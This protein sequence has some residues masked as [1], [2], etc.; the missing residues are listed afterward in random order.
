MASDLVHMEGIAKS[1]GP[2]TALDGV[3]FSVRENEIVGLLG[4]NGAGKSTLIKILSGTVT[5]TR[6]TIYMRGK[7]VQI[8]NTTDAIRLGI[9][10]IHQDSALV[11]QLS[12]ARNLFLG[13]EPL[14]GPALLNRM[15]KRMMNEVAG[16]LLKEIGIT[17]DIPATTP[18]SSLSGG[19]RQAVSIARALHFDSDLIVLDEPTNNL[20]VEETQGVM[21]FMRNARDSGHSLIFIAHN[22]HHVFQVVDRIV[23]L[24]RGK[25]VANDVDPKQTT[26]EAVERIITG[27]PAD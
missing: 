9:E 2:V 5:A 4:D 11:T 13:R 18:I 7:Q 25:V 15:D 26:I 27:L 23:V 3:D 10:T 8:R 6:G 22:I 14:V 20:G 16:K 17:K 1:Y 21:R 19:E 24:R 12:I